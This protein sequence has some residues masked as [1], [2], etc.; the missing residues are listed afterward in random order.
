HFTLPFCILLFPP[1]PFRTL[2]LSAKDKYYHVHKA[3]KFTIQLM[4]HDALN[5]HE[6]FWGVKECK[7][8]FIQ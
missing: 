1:K 8:I 7:R 3:N 5:I 6:Y 4:I 2:Y